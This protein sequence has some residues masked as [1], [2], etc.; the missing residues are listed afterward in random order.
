LSQCRQDDTG[1]RI[2]PA[3][4]ELV[5]FSEALLLLMT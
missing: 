4:F 2:A 5:T 3:D 1:P